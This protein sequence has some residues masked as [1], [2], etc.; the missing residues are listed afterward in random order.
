MGK[1]SVTELDNG[2]AHEIIGED[3]V[4]HSYVMG[5]CLVNLLADTKVYGIPERHLVEEKTFKLI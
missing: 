3:Y 5:D 4:G 2:R 1:C